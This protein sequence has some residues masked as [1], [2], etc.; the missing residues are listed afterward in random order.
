[1]VSAILLLSLPKIF[2]FRNGRKSGQQKWSFFFKDAIRSIATQVGLK[3]MQFFQKKNG[4]TPLVYIG[5]GPFQ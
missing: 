1:M 3:H 2:I 5:C 4:R